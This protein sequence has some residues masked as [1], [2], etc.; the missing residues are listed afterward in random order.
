MLICRNAEKVRGEKKVG[1]PELEGVEAQPISSKTHI[2][3]LH[4]DWTVDVS[5]VNK[6]KIL[7]YHL[8]V[9]DILQK[10]KSHDKRNRCR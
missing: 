10:I 4:R 9:I 1:N 5:Q 3:Q 2:L 6:L 8:T 7:A